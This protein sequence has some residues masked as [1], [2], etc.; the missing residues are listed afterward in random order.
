MSPDSRSSISLAKTLCFLRDGFEYE[1]LEQENNHAS[2]IKFP[3]ED[4]QY[5]AGD[6]LVIMDKEDIV[7]HGMIGQITDGFATA[8]DHRASL[9][10]STAAE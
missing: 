8:T 1:T 10:P 3:L 6:V 4:P 5:T 7:F 9:L 2:V